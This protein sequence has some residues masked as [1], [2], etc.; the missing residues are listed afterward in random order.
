MILKNHYDSI[1]NHVIMIDLL[2]V[3]SAYYFTEDKDYSYWYSSLRTYDG[4]LGRYLA[5]AFEDE[6]N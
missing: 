1:T 2:S 5:H 6:V 3:P 4:V